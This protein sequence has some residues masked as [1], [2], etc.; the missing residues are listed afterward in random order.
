[1]LRQDL[2]AFTKKN[3]PRCLQGPKEYLPSFLRLLP[4]GALYS[5]SIFP[6][7]SSYLVRLTFKKGY[8]LADS[9]SNRRKKGNT[10]GKEEEPI[11]TNIN[12]YPN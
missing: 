11:S 5:S 2:F 8:M 10:L 1:L 6:F 9:N 7:F 4:A 3:N 12:E